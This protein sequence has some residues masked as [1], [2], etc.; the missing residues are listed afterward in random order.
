M[1]YPGPALGVGARPPCARVPEPVIWRGLRIEA[2]VYCGTASA[3]PSTPPRLQPP[4]RRGCAA[5]VVPRWRQRRGART[6]AW[7]VDSSSPASTQSRTERL[8]PAWHPSGTATQ[9]RVCQDWTVAAGRDTGSKLGRVALCAVC[10]DVALPSLHQGPDG[11]R[12]GEERRADPHHDLDVVHEGAVVLV[13]QAHADERSVLH[14][15]RT[16]DGGPR[17]TGAVVT[18][19]TPR[20]CGGL[21]GSP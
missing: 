11:Y 19:A 8:I 6:L 1:D 4:R 20:L 21:P 15:P 12:L 10:G 16:C 13:E 18:P 7:T 9:Y 3:Q 2:F 5:G 17:S 14:A